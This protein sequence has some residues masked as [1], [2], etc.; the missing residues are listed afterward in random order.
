MIWAEEDCFPRT[1][2][3]MESD[4]REES[5]HSKLKWIAVTVSGDCSAVERPGRWC[6]LILVLTG[7]AVVVNTTEQATKFYKTLYH[8]PLLI[9]APQ[10]QVCTQNIFRVVM[11]FVWDVWT[12]NKLEGKGCYVCHF[13]YESVVSHYNS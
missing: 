5:T 9:T 8:I 10:N 2:P 6:E 1:W 12:H 13:V 7:Q 11:S 4:A 3:D